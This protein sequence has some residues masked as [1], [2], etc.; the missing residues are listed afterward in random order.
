MV[1]R[2]SFIVWTLYCREGAYTTHLKGGLIGPLKIICMYYAYKWF[3]QRS[4]AFV[5][6]L[7]YL[8][9]VVVNTCFQDVLFTRYCNYS[10]CKSWGC[11]VHTV[12]VYG[13]A[14]V[15]LSSFLTSTQ[16]EVNGQLHDL[17]T[18]SFGEKPPVSTE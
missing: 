8:V 17:V 18:L 14:E 7:L 1:V 4:V 15:Q 5:T 16:M 9:S 10:F 3:V 12:K 6:V 11:P 2:F 13:R